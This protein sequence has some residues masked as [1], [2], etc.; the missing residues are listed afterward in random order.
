MFCM[1]SEDDRATTTGNMYTADNCV[2]SGR[3]VF[4]TC[5]RAGRQTNRQT[6]N[7]ADCN[8]LHPY[9]RRSKKQS[10][11]VNRI[12]VSCARVQNTHPSL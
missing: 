11:D 10:T 4:E 12:Y 5:E 7:D 1:V 6:Y 2:K 8:T 9:R 3:L